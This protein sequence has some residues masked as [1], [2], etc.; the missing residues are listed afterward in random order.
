MAAILT[1]AVRDFIIYS[2]GRSAEED[3]IAEAAREWLFEGSEEDGHITSFH[4][5]CLAMDLDCD[6]VRAQIHK[7]QSRGKPKGLT[8]GSWTA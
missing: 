7:M 6:R 8:Y 1:R 5:I 4:N 2:R 3:H